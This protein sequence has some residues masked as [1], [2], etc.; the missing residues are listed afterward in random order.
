MKSS[1]SRGQGR[2]EY[3]R[4]LPSITVDFTSDSLMPDPGE[5][6]KRIINRHVLSRSRVSD[7]RGE[8]KAG[9][10]SRHHDLLLPHRNSR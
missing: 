4:R 9:P 6:G 1:V 3:E 2:G 10:P 8:S 5:R 7:I